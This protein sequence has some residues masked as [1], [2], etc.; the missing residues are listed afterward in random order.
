M[1]D[2]CRMDEQIVRVRWL[3]D[4]MIAAGGIMEF[5]KVL[6]GGGWGQSAI[7]GPGGAWKG[8]QS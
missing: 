2:L 7:M 6:C 4:P 3:P 5:D 1:D 8:W